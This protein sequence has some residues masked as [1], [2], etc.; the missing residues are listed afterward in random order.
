MKEKIKKENIN[1]LIFSL[2]N[3]YFA[4]L[5]FSYFCILYL[6]NGNFRVLNKVNKF[7]I[8]YAIKNSS[9]IFSISV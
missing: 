3:K 9:F 4:K 2:S 7:N 8:N 1:H 6:L 5:I